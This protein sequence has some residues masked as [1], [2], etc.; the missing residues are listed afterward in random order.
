MQKTMIEISFCLQSFFVVVYFKVTVSIQR[1]EM[2]FDN[3]QIKNQ[4][5]I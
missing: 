2:H 1:V 5:I 3:N 4:K